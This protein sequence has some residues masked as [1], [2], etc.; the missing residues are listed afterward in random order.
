MTDLLSSEE[1]VIDKA[2]KLLGQEESFNLEFR[3]HFEE[4]LN[5][6]IKLNKGQKHKY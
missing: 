4:L 2:R 6:Y 1:T 3:S 5:A